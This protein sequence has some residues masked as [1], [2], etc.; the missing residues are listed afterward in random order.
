MHMGVGTV[1]PATIAAGGDAAGVIVPREALLRTAGQTFAYVRRAA[2]SFERRPVVGG[3]STPS[4]IFV[5][6]GFRAGEQ[7]VVKGAA[8][9]FAAETPSSKAD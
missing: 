3:V 6:G 2:A 1:A 4:G 7:V 9:L 5:S 8:Q